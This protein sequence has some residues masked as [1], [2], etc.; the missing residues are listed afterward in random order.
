M[1]GRGRFQKAA[2]IGTGMMGPGIAAIL[3]LGGVHVT[4]LSRRLE[5]AQEGLAKARSCVN[6]L[7]V[8]FLGGP[9]KAELSASDDMTAA[10]R[11]CDLVIESAPE[12]MAFKQDLFATLEESVRP[13]AVLA[14]NTSGL[15]ITAIAS[16]CKHPERVLTTHFW[17]PPHLMPLVELVKG[18]KTSPAIAEE[19]R[20]LMKYCRKVPVMVKRDTP[21]QLGNRLQMALWREAAHILESGI[22][23]V[24]DIDLA[25][26]N[27][28]GLRLPVYGAFEHADMVGLDMAGAIFDYVTR[29]LS[30]QQGL[31]EGLKQ[32][33]ADGQLGV[34]SGSGFYDWSK[35]DAKKVRALRDEFV[36]DVV[37]RYRDGDGDGN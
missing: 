23:D 33:L 36:L 14:S 26:K 17:N 1:T 2:V 22:A 27:G 15:S 12:N 3:A 19:I 11:D 10:T 6:E 21:G 13:D 18:E 16:K 35:R 31:T 5:S 25:I 7:M 37:K 29:D 20:D 34:K 8:D 30:N 32:R 9:E 28:F 24:E 4:V